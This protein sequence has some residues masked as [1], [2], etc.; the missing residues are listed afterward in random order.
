MASSCG[1]APFEGDNP[2]EC[3]DGADNDRDGRFDCG[4][5][6]CTGAPACVPAPVEPVVP[7][8]PIAAPAPPPVAKSDVEGVH[9]Y[10]LQDWVLRVEVR[11]TNV[12]IFGAV[13]NSDAMPCVSS[14]LRPGRRVESLSRATGEDHGQREDR[15]PRHRN[16]PRGGATCGGTRGGSAN[17]ATAERKRELEVG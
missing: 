7:V 13:L 11:G 2:G 17:K 1:P 9:C 10:G 12:V 5:E 3:A 16:R 4:D 6:G 15:D 8:A 14:R